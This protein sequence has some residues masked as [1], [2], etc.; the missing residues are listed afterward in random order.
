ML[1][2]LIM[3]F[4]SVFSDWFTVL[5]ILVGVLIGLTMGSIPG[6]TGNMAVALLIPLTYA[7][8]P[9]AAVSFLIAIT[10]AG[11]FGGSIP[12]I[13][14]NTPGTPAA[15]ATAMDGYEL[16]KRARPSRR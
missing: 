8:P 5:L 2:Q 16:A 12:A 15:T 14:I 7:M 10:K 13:L 11:T 6:L 1:E 4:G 3:G 9:V